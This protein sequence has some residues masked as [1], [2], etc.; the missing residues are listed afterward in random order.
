MQGRLG[1]GLLTRRDQPSDTLISTIISSP[2]SSSSER[3]ASVLVAGGA[4]ST[5]QGLE[6][7]P[8]CHRSVPHV[9]GELVD[10]DA[11]GGEGSGDLRDDAG[12]VGPEQLE[13]QPQRLALDGLVGAFDVDLQPG[14]F[15]AVR[16]AT[17]A[18]SRSSATA[19]S[20]LP[21]NLPATWDSWLSSQ[22][23]PCALIAAERADTTPGPVVA[24]DGEDEGGHDLTRPSAGGSPR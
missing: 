24:G 5:A 23:A 13:V 8:A 1:H 16:S 18:S 4:L 10:V 6:Q 20:T 7:G 14:S 11:V 9:G 12:A 22:L 17:S 2:S 21:A 19:T 15:S 3:S